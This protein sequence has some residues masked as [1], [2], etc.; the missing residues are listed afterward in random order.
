[1]E[2]TRLL[3]DT[4]IDHWVAAGLI[5][6]AQADEIRAAEHLPVRRKAAPDIIS[7]AAEPQLVLPQE[8]GADLPER[9]SLVAEAL[10]YLGG[11]L[12][13]VASV[14]ITS[15]VWSSMSSIARLI[16]VGVVTA[17]LLVAGEAVPAERGAVGERFR[18]ALWLLATASFVGF[19]ALF[20]TDILEW[21]GNGV[22]VAT[23][24]TGAGFA[25]L[26]WL[27]NRT[28]LQEAAFFVALAVAVATLANLAA[29]G[30][31][32]A[33]GRV[34]LPGVAVLCVGMIW[35]L[36]DW[37]RRVGH[38][39]LGQIGGAALMGFG[40]MLVMGRGWAGVLG[41]VVVGL[42]VAAAVWM[43]SLA[44]LVIAAVT[45]L[46]V[47]PRLLAEYF[48]GALAGALALVVV[49]LVMVGLAVRLA[50]RPSV[51]GG[52][53]HSRISA[54]ASLI[55]AAVVALSLGLTLLVT[56]VLLA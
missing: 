40:A 34:I 26:M 54:D 30:D 3:L 10:G 39:P 21:E 12:V 5:S 49:G 27:A 19:V 9:A 31:R 22:A 7:V 36:L 4:Q 52:P 55:A 28:G 23:S 45:A 14:W 8:D 43:R 29:T 35:L 44:V 38:H 6:A 46:Q 51:A 56:A 15:Q 48:G 17:M 33:T 1:M 11:M 13:L 47:F 37:G 24:A 16:L 2:R 42:L 18:S 50:R 53:D 32:P 20:L 25:A 41:L